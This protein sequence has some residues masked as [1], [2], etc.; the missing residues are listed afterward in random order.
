MHPDTEA[1]PAEL[2]A[3]ALA[4]EGTGYALALLERIGRGV[5]NPDDLAAVVQFMHSGPMLQGCS[6]VLFAA[7]RHA[8]AHGFTW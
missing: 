7:L 5:S 4:S 8:T 6:L 3:D 1:R 2:S